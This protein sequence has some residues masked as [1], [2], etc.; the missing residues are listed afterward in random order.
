MPTLNLSDD[1]VAELA[2]QWPPPSRRAL[3]LAL[4]RE[5]LQ[6]LDLAIL[7]ARATPGLESAL[8]ARGSDL[9]AMTPNQVE[10]A[11]QDICEEP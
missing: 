6:I 9:R 11:V 1:Q 3:G 4:L 5:T 7:R 10:R 8:N 2:M